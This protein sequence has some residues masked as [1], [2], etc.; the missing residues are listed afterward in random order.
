MVSKQTVLGLLEQ[1]LDYHQVA[2]RTGVSAGTAY[3]IAT[4]MPADGGDS[5]TQEMRER[6]GAFRSR[7]QLLVHAPEENQ[8]TKPEVLAWVQERVAADVQQRAAGQVATQS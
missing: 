7:S 3:L 5:Y 6:P 4:G 8:T 1:G 2:A